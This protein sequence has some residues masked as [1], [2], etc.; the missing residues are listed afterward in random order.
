MGAVWEYGN[1]SLPSG[2]R[3][4]GSKALIIRGRSR[5]PGG[6]PH[7]RR[8]PIVSDRSWHLLSCVQF[9]SG[10][11]ALTFS[12]RTAD[13]GSELVK[14]PGTLPLRFS[15]DRKCQSSPS[16]GH[17]SD[18]IR[19]GE[20]GFFFFL[21]IIYLFIYGC[22]GSSFLCEGFLQLR[23]TGATLHR[24]ARASHYR[25]L[26]CCRAQAPDAQAQ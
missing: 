25:G 24:G 14:L 1:S 19:G 20:C 7:A 13:A 26:S 5:G 11:T 18:Q 2:Q 17:S 10:I 12:R 23:Q 4:M 16:K 21:I 9:T 15:F 22:V 6:P 3:R 8:C